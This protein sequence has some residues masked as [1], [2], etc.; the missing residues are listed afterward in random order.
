MDIFTRKEQL[1]KDGRCS[2]TLTLTLTCTC[3]LTRTLRRCFTLTLTGTLFLL[4]SV[5]LT[6]DCRSLSV[7]CLSCTVNPC[8]VLCVLACTRISCSCDVFFFFPFLSLSLSLSLVDAWYC[9]DCDTHREANKQFVLYRLPN[10]L[11]VCERECT[12]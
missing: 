9:R 6:L 7:L 4:P 2:C 10:I 3:S 5:S 8:V 11:I 1:S 12:S